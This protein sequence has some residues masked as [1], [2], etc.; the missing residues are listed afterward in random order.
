MAAIGSNLGQHRKSNK[1]KKNIY[2]G[3]TFTYTEDCDESINRR[4]LKTCNTCKVTRPEKCNIKQDH[5]QNKPA[6]RAY[7][8]QDRVKCQHDSKISYSIYQNY[9]TFYIILIRY[10]NLYNFIT[11]FDLTM[12]LNVRDPKSIYWLNEA[13]YNYRCLSLSCTFISLQQAF[14]ER[15]L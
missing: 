4:N 12:L 6:I 15:K 11:Y 13:L 7:R 2:G 9:Q 3:S 8:S 10:P 5:L 14:D 1:E